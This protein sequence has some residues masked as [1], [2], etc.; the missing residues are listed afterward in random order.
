MGITIWEVMARKIPF[1]SAKMNVM[2]LIEAVQKGGKNSRLKITPGYNIQL[3]HVG[4]RPPLNELS[5]E[6]PDS[7]K[8]LMEACWHHDPEKRPSMQE[9]HNALGNILSNSF[10]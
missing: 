9:L 3:F 1:L 7:L 5:K 2:K 4:L 8:T 6:C 10:K